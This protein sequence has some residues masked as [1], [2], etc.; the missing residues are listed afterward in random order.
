MVAVV[1]L[2]MLPGV[3]AARSGL[4]AGD[5]LRFGVCSSLRLLLPRVEG[6]TTKTRS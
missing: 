6:T 4:D 2:L 3:D 1:A 5:L